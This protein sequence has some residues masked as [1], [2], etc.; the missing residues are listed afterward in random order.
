MEDPAI[1]ER[2]IPGKRG[3]ADEGTGYERV[4][5][6]RGG[7]HS[8]H[9]VEYVGGGIPGGGNPGPGK[10]PPKT[11]DPTSPEAYMKGKGKGQRTQ[12]GRYRIDRHQMQL[13]YEWGR[14]PNGCT[15]VCCSVPKRSYLCEFCLATHRSIT[16]G[17]KPKGFV[18]PGKN[19]GKGGDDWKG[20]NKNA[21]KPHS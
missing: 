5:R 14:N 15:D 11:L 19:P 3:T 8:L 16:C 21:W 6:R 18:F 7:K 2:T 12:D 10:G 17:K 13:C 20:W 4:K 1:D 9:G